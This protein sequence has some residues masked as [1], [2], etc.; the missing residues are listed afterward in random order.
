MRRLLPIFLFVSCAFGQHLGFDRNDY[1]GDN[2]LAQ[3]RKTFE[4]TGYWLNTPPGA[5]S[6]S[7]LGKRK[8]VEQ[9]GFGFVVLYNGKTYA[10]LRGSEAEEAG[11]A[12]GLAA[13]ADAKKEGFPAGTIIFL[14]QEEGGR[15]LQEQKEYLFA[16]VDAVIANGY[17]AGVY[18][19]G[20]PVAEK[21]SGE[22]I[23]TADDIKESAGERKIT[24]FVA[25]DTCP[26]SS[27]C[28][29]KPPQPYLS[30][31][32]YAD[33]WQYAQSPRRSPQTDS[34]AQT[35]ASDGNCYPPDLKIHVDLSTAISADPSHGRS[36][37]QGSPSSTARKSG[38]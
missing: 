29:L 38:V 18:C 33:I 36:T 6:N 7:W 32:A 23:I 14:D 20:I 17:R 16:W 25:Q 4:F 5:K 22:T 8:L 3:L 31:I 37:Q 10:Q 2:N 26:P 9:A 11:S 28:T 34:C 12:D 19:S 15:L 1:P 13:T 21:D 27:G 24:Y 35:Y 30:G